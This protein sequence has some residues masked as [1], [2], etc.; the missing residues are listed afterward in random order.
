MPMILIA[1]SEPEILDDPV[2]EFEEVK[3]DLKTCFFC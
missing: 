2:R 1:E 3:F